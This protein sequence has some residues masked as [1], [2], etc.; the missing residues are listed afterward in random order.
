M[1][2]N[3]ILKP[4]R[5]ILSLPNPRYCS[6]KAVSKPK[7]TK[8]PKSG[9]TFQD[10]LASSNFQTRVS[11]IKRTP[12]DA[13]P[14]INEELLSGHGFKVYLDVYG[15]QMNVND[16]EV[17][18]SI[19]ESKGYARTLNK[20]EADIWL[21][22]TCSIREGAETRIWNVLKGI[23]NS[24]KTGACKKSLKIGLLGCMAERLKDKMLGT[25]LVDLVAGPDAYRDLP[26]LLAVTEH[27]NQAAINVMLSMDE[28]YADVK[29]AR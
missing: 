24:S 19:L 28:T 2:K 7:A 5:L 22:I 12:E 3:H 21:L 18:W 14:Y 23:R 4:N 15:C 16:T 17:V 1:L 13:I 29:P 25:D 8:I 10:F 6:A 26:R 27:S 20:S 11:S 9:P